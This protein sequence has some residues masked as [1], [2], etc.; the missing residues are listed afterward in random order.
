[1]HSRYDIVLDGYCKTLNIEALTMLEMV[2]RNILPAACAYVRDLSET[3]IAKKGVVSG[4][5][6]FG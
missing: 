1:M 6:L 5:F 2:K 3:A 4:H